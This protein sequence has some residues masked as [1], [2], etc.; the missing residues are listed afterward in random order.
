MF[1][2]P[3]FLMLSIL[4]AVMVVS[5]TACSDFIKPKNETSSERGIPIARYKNEYLYLGDISEALTGAENKS[6]SLDIINRIA[7]NWLKNKVLIDKAMLNLGD[8]IKKIE[9]QIEDYRRDLIIYAYEQAYINQNLDTNISQSEIIEYYQNNKNNFLL[10]ENIVVCD[11]AI[12]PKS[13]PKI[14]DIKKYFFSAKTKKEIAQVEEAAL[15]YARVYAYGDT[16][17][18]SLPEIVKIIPFVS[19]V[20]ISA[21]S[22]KQFVF[23]D[24]AFI[25]LLHIRQIKTKN[26]PA[27][28][29]YVSESIRNTLLNTRKLELLSQLESNLLVQALQQNLIEIIVTDNIHKQ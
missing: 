9:K 3:Q 27:P 14:A 24:E 19:E 4:Q 20:L 8:E 2:T 18:F 5:I 6:D 22:P 28:L 15:K 11:Y 21:S 12:F 7:Q 10:R 29:D 17:W 23:E 26:S 16:S 25:Y 13:T 1:Q